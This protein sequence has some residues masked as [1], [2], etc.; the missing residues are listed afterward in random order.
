MNGI[1]SSAFVT[2]AVA[3]AASLTFAKDAYLDDIRVHLSGAGGA[4]NLVIQ[5]NSIQGSAYDV[6]LYTQDM[7]A[8]TDF[9]FQPDPKIHFL[10]GDILEVTWANG[11]GRTYGVEFIYTEIKEVF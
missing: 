2:G 8:H 10:K 3:M 4:G 6:V 5:L 11:S 7:T 9:I 1:T